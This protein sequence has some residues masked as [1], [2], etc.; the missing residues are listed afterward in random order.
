MMVVDPDEQ[1]QQIENYLKQIQQQC[2][3]SQVQTSKIQYIE[4]KTFESKFEQPKQKLI[5]DG[6]RFQEQI[7]YHGTSPAAIESILKNNYDLKRAA[8]SPAGKYIDINK[9][10]LLF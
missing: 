2:Q 6:I 4:N 3:K 5:Q 1:K 8:S 7:M 9:N 10:I